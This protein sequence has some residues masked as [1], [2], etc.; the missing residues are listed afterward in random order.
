[1]QA[2]ISTC[3]QFQIKRSLNDNK[4]EDSIQYTTKNTI[5]ATKVAECSKLLEHNG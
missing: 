4:K 3:D 5:I 1:M 2:N